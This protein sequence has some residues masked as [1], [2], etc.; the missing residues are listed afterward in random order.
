MCEAG[1]YNV[2]GV[3]DSLSGRRRR[4]SRIR[5]MIRRRRKK[6]KRER[7]SEAWRRVIDKVLTLMM[8]VA[9]LLVSWELWY[10]C[11]YRRSSGSGKMKHLVCSVGIFSL[12]CTITLPIILLDLFPCIFFYFS[13]TFLLII[14]HLVRFSF[15]LFYLL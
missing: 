2:A 10:V 9:C 13:L 14:I 8:S 5:R 6:K 12:C 11:M 1:Y 3:K 15:F 7:K 4:R